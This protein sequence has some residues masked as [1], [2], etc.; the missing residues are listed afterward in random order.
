[1]AL[2]EAIHSCY[3]VGGS[4]ATAAGMVKMEPVCIPIIIMMIAIG[5][6]CG[7]INDWLDRDTGSLLR[8]IVGF[9]MT[10]LI[11]FITLAAIGAVLISSPS[12]M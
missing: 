4:R 3:N 6:G 9:A 5:I 12:G 1:M 10:A 7:V 2:N 11:F 8:L